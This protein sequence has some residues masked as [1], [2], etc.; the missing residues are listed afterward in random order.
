MLV[1]KETVPRL[2]Q[3]ILLRNASDSMCSHERSDDQTIYNSLSVTQTH[4][5]FAT[6][7]I[8]DDIH[9]TMID[10]VE[11]FNSLVRILLI[12]SLIEEIEVIFFRR[13][14]KYFCM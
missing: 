1:N 2:D 9:I 14:G 12:I 7:A 11:K 3:V 13:Y 5:H 4:Y 6:L 8:P 10:W